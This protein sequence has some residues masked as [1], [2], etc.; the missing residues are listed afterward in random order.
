MSRDRE[1]KQRTDL[2]RS[3]LEL[4]ASSTEA[5]SARRNELDQLSIAELKLALKVARGPRGT[6]RADKTAPD[7]V[8]ETMFASDQEWLTMHEIAEQARARGHKI[9]TERVSTALS[10]LECA[11]GRN[12][13]LYDG[14]GVEV[15]RKQRP[16][17]FRIIT[18]TEHDLRRGSGTLYLVTIQD[19][20]IYGHPEVAF[21]LIAAHDEQTACSYAGRVLG[22][23]ADQG[24][25]NCAASARQLNIGTFY[26][27]R[28]RTHLS[29][30]LKVGR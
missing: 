21:A 8:L 13:G 23:L 29:P 26:E 25:R 15:I 6:K 17:L 30:D 24:H 22:E 20:N 16:H 9:E 10:N 19:K 11:R 12:R 1:R 7:I 14:Y 3:I 18:T 28:T 27:P 2:T 5:K 4:D